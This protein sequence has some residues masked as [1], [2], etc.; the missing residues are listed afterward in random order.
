MDTELF[1]KKA[2]KVHGNKYDYSKV[3]YIGTMKKVKIECPEH[4]IF[5]Q[6]PK[7]HLMGKECLDCSRVTASKT[8]AMSQEDFIKKAAEK[9]DSKYDYSMVE[10]KNSRTKVVIICKEHGVFEQTPN[11]FFNGRVCKECK[12]SKDA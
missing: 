11:A 8:K 6:I 12:K 3:E 10:Y 5:K 4:G 1:I 7:S 9:Y 2:R